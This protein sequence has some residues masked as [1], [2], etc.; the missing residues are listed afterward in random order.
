MFTNSEGVLMRRYRY[1]LDV[2]DKETEDLVAN[3][4]AKLRQN[5]I[6]NGMVDHIDQ[7]RVNDDIRYWEIVDPDETACTA[8][9]AKLRHAVQAVWIPAKMWRRRTQRES[10]ARTAAIGHVSSHGTL[11]H[12]N[13]LLSDTARYSKP[14]KGILS[15]PD[16]S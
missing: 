11:Y 5:F 12:R 6:E 3:G 16:E 1:I 13:P 15:V 2:D 9:E 14:V 7:V 8:G 10:S 4:A